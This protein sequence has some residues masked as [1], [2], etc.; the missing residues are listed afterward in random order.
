[1]KY[2]IDNTTE[3]IKLDYPK[4]IRVKIIDL[5]I[6][7]TEVPFEHILHISKITRDKKYG[8]P[9]SYG[10][11]DETLYLFP[12]PNRQMVLDIEY[13]IPEPIYR[14]RLEEVE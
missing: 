5:Q 2:I 9:A 12:F 7:L 3:S 13:V 14:N 6:L 11:N 8:V 10:I 4:V 1:M